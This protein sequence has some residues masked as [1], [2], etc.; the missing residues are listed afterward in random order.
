M[1]I[2]QDGLSSRL[3]RSMTA[4]GVHPDHERLALPGAAAHTVLQCG[5]VLQGVEGHHPVVMVTS[6]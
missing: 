2:L 4:A 5:T 6:Q 1:C 3:A